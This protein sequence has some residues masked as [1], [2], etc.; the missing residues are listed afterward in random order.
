MFHFV[1]M[2]LFLIRSII[3]LARNQAIKCVSWAC[4]YEQGLKSTVK[5]HTQEPSLCVIHHLSYH[6]FL[7]KTDKHSTMILLQMTKIL[8]KPTKIHYV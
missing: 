1:I 5:R 7:R 6:H 3:S 2:Y 8:L 4:Q